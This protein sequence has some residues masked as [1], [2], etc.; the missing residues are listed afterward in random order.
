MVVREGTK[1][2]M[3]ID[4][5]LQRVWRYQKADAKA[6]H[7]H[8][9]VRREPGRLKYSLSNANETTAVTRLA[10]MQGQ[11]Y[12]VER[13][14]QDAK[15]QGGLGE[16]QVRNWRGW[17]HHTALVM[18][19]MLFITQERLELGEGQLTAADVQ[20]MLVHYL[21]RRGRTEDD[22]LAALRT[23]LARRGETLA[24]DLPEK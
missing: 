13:A 4:I 23:R 24:Y 2:A 16:Y 9:V 1:G 17:H 12:F 21:P 20:M 19:S 10:Y 7:W 22:M 5:L 14:L 3:E 18:L 15:Q 6:Y 8:L 11:R